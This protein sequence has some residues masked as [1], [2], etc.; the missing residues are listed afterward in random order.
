MKASVVYETA[1]LYLRKALIYPAHI[2]KPGACTLYASA[3]N[4]NHPREGERSTLPTQLFNTRSL[5][6]LT[7]ETLEMGMQ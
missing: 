6:K 3:Q 1:L 5:T 2:T 4:C 7:F